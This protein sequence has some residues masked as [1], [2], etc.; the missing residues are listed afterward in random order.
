MAVCL[1]LPGRWMISPELCT[2]PTWRAHLWLQL[3]PH[4]L[5]ALPRASAG[6]PKSCPAPHRHGHQLHPFRV[7][8]DTG[9]RPGPKGASSV[10]LRATAR[11]AVVPCETDTAGQRLSSHQQEQEHVG[12]M[13]HSDTGEDLTRRVTS[14]G[15]ARVLLFE[16][17][18][19][20][21]GCVALPTVP[22]MS[23]AVR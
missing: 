16:G 19:A 3:L 23:A 8:A 2:R 21:L 10:L 5:C 11:P 14:R 9:P 4:I 20:S 17:C 18:E 13:M 7:P 1:C 22:C 6:Q 12:T 15:T